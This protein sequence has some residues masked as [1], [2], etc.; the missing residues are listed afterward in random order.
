MVQLAD[1]LMDMVSLVA[2]PGAFLV[3]AIPICK[4]KFK[5]PELGCEC[6]LNMLT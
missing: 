4:A 5:Y 1:E 2:I 6:I 3:D